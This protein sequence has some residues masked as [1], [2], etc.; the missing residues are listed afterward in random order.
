[1]S[2]H[3]KSYR[4]AQ[5]KVAQSKEYDLSEGISLIKE[6]SYAKFD[7]SI[8]VS[9]KLGVDPKH[10]DQMVRGSVV[11]PHGIGKTQRVVVFAKGEKVS[12]AREAGADDVGADDLAEKIQSGWM[13]F[14]RVV[15]TP[16]V[17]NIVGKLGRV[18]GPRGLMPNP[19]SGSVSFDVGR[20]VKEIKAG[21]VEYRVDKEANVHAL[22]GKIS[23]EVDAL[24]ENISTLTD[25]LVRAKPA[26]SKGV[27]FKALTISSTMGP[28]VKID[29][30]ALLASIS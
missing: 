23:F 24:F 26:S 10:A 7:E 25:T 2:R 19:K 27:Y 13:E 29:H 18:L 8:E 14:D 30:Q 17:M 20:M 22:V 16:D 11:L 21:K 4:N 9:I 5:E 6:V 1:M 28:A 15:A 3:G 12:E